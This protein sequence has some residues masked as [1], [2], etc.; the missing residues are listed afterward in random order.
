[1]AT[2]M[3]TTWAA[4]DASVNTVIGNSLKPVRARVRQLIR[5]FPCLARAVKVSVDYTVGE[6]IRFQSRVKNAE[7]KLDSRR[8]Q[9]IEDA[10][11]FWADE[12]DLARKLHY[13]ELM[14]LAKRQDLQDIMDAEL[15]ASK[16]AAKYLA[17]L[18]KADP[19]FRQAAAGARPDDSGKK[20]ETLENAVIE[21]LRPGE[22]V[23]LTTNPR[24]GTNFPPFAKLVLIMF[25]IVSGVPYELLSGNYEGLNCAVSRMVRNDFAHQLRPIAGR[26]GVDRPAARG[27]GPRGRDPGRPALAPG[28]SPG[29]RPRPRGGPGRNR[30]GP[31][32]GRGQGC[33]RL[34]R[35]VHRVHGRHRQPGRCGGPAQIRDGPAA[36]LRLPHRRPRMNPMPFAF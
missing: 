34:P 21:Y 4:L 3:F 18:K 32:D 2:S 7:G 19:A 17:L 23:V 1:M 22:D 6:G 30:P 24:P 13:Y 8:S 25:S 11:S 31:P 5:D 29:A 15:D 35:P 28:I 20:I 14:A 26:H 36:A 33:R 10:F 16:M 12:A 9:K 27:Q